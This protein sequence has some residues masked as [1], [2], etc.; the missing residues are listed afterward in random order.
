MI[1]NDTI[2]N[3]DCLEVINE[4]QSQ[5]H[6]NN[7]NLI[8]K[9]T[10]TP[11]N[12][13]ITCPY[14]KDGQERRP[15]AGIHKE[16]GVFHCLACGE[17]HSLPEVI[18]YCFNWNDMFGKRGLNWLLENFNSIQIE[19]RKLDFNIKRGK[20]VEEPTYVS[21]EELDKYRYT[22]TYWT[23]RNI[24]DD[25]IIELFDLGYDKDTQCITFPVRDE[26]G[27]CLFVARRSVHTKYFNYPAGADKPLYGL[28]ELSKYDNVS[29]IYITESMIDCILLWQ[30][31]KFAIA[32]NGT[33]S[34]EQLKMLE[35][36]PCRKL[37]LATD[38]DEAGYNARKKIRRY[39]TNKIVTE[40]EFPPNRKDIGECTKEEIE[41]LKEIL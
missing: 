40:I 27:N 12:V 35:K 3:A 38:N 32:L 31:G 24:V 2:I 28:Y 4:L 22:H 9:I 16:T 19:N 30:S 1:I 6:S 13:M 18:S 21:E 41:N 17:T 29:K 25:D 7:I 15:S 20:E 37:V 34:K 8:N 23:Y 26:K 11:D 14:H 10:N 33:G 36:L 39:I 5:L